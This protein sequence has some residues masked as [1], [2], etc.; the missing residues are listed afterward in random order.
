MRHTQNGK[1]KTNWYSHSHKSRPLTRRPTP[2]MMMWRQLRAFFIFHF[3]SFAARLF[4]LFL[5]TWL[6]LAIRSQHFANTNSLFA[7]L[8]ICRL[9]EGLAVW[10]R[11]RR[12]ARK[13]NGFCD[14]FLYFSFSGY[15]W[16]RFASL[17]D[18]RRLKS[19][20][21]LR[22]VCQLKLHH[23]T[24]EKYHKFLLHIWHFQCA[25]CRSYGWF[26]LSRVGSVSA[27]TEFNLDFQLNSINQLHQ[28]ALFGE[29]GRRWSKEVIFSTSL[30]VLQDDGLLR[31]HSCFLHYNFARGLRAKSCLSLFDIVFLS[32]MF[33]LYAGRLCFCRVCIALH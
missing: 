32:T 7:K 10:M 5:S 16:S 33:S 27:R 9:A 22:L 28:Y 1:T 13:T 18:S 29:V 14:R 3:H 17:V 19:I 15:Y 6:W 20:R 8:N 24:I 25:C 2:I 12:I 26:C 11:G 4:F 23:S 30:L 21:L 31:I